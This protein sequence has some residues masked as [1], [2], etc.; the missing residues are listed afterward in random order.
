MPVVALVRRLSAWCELASED[1]PRLSFD[2]YETA[3]LDDG[4]V[5]TLHRD[6][7]FTTLVNAVGGPQPNNAW[8][9]ESAESIRA[10]VMTAVLPDDDGPQDEH[11]WPWLVTL[12]GDQGVT[13]TEADLKAV[14][15]TV[16]FGPVLRRRLAETEALREG[17]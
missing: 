3:V 1:G 6:R 2:V 14:P 10:S 12:L 8:P 13:V 16:E 5:L 17:G 7:G 15:Y 4:R 11:P 9:Y